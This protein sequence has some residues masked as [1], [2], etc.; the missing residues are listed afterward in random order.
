MAVFLLLA[1]AGPAFQPPACTA[2]VFADVPCSHPFA[3]WINELAARG[4]TGGCGGGD[5]CPGSPVSR[6]QMAVFLLL[7]SE[8]AAFSPPAC[9]S[10]AFADVPCA[11]PFAPWVNELARRGITGG[12]GNGAF[13]PAIT[14]TREQMAVFLS[15][16][17]GLPV[18][19]LGCLLPVI[20]DD[21]GDLPAT[22]TLV[23]LSPAAPGAQVAGQLERPRDRDV[24]AFLV[25]AG[26]LYFVSSDVQPG[27]QPALR[28]LTAG[29]EVVAEA[30]FT[31]SPELTFTAASGGTFFLEVSDS[32]RRWTG[33][34]QLTLRGP[35]ADD[36]GDTAGAA[37]PVPLGA[38]GGSALGEIEFTGDIDAFSFLAAADQVFEIEVESPAANEVQ[39]VDMFLLDRDGSSILAETRTGPL[40]KILLTAP[41]TGRYFVVFLAPRGPYQFRVRGPIADDHGDTV[42]SAT[43]LTPGSPVDGELAGSDVDYFSFTAGTGERFS[44]DL[45]H[46]D[47]SADYTV[48]VLKGDGVSVLASTRASYGSSVARLFSTIPTAGIYFARVSPTFSSVRIAYYRIELRKPILDD[49]GDSPATA[50]PLT[51]G[52][53]MNGANE[54]PGDLDFFSFEANAGERFA[55]DDLGAQNGGSSIRLTLLG[56]DGVDLEAVPGEGFVAPATGTFYLRVQ[57]V[58]GL[59]TLT[60]TYQIR[61]RG[62]L[63]D[64]H[65]D[66]TAMATP[67]VPDGPTVAGRLDLPFDK[68]V[69]SFPG[70]AGTIV[71]IKL[72]GVAAQDVLAF[73]LLDTDGL[74]NLTQGFDFGE[75]TREITFQAPRTGTFCFQLESGGQIEN[76]GYQIRV[77]QGP[78]E[79]HGNTPETATLLQ[80]DGPPVPGFIEPAG[81]QDYFAFDGAQGQTVVIDTVVTGLGSDTVIDLFDA[82]GPTFLGFDD[83]GGANGGSRIVFT[84]AHSGRYLVRVRHLLFATGTYTIAVHTP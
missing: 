44:L 65:G 80:V 57:H 25:Q 26:G 39:P 71:Q 24:F 53:T 20:P 45:S 17:F 40:A 52:V 18:P 36:H 70:V 59:D 43:P 23:S 74:T 16:A 41:A 56:E 83:D 14:V 66:T 31:S 28:L 6:E 4:I 15:T 27:L 61:G 73:R 72:V 58:S 2:P 82:V 81:D 60:G 22:A 19:S 29:G 75:E 32:L 54:F 34:Y 48:Q 51:F 10:Q 76:G 79:D 55:F 5:F 63:A 78:L 64:D 50:T 21:H 77:I 3:A 11:S 47:P 68:D 37:T 35:I 8:G 62:P 38:G 46:L 49:H 12:C 30:S 1:S 7:A 69:F 9:T 13:C 84:P 67:L 42:G 33:P